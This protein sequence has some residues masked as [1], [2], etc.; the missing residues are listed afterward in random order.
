MRAP[1]CPA[2]GTSLT[3]TPAGVQEESVGRVLAN[4][5]GDQAAKRLIGRAGVALRLG[6]FRISRMIAMS[7]RV[8]PR[9]TGIRAIE[10]SRS[11]RG[12][13]ASIRRY[14]FAHPGEVS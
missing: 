7:S 6:Y 11:T 9:S 5:P 1:R 14:V 8:V 13:V 10:M 3:G 2:A 4:R 12:T